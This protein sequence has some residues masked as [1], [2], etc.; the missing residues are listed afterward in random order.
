LAGT[1][2]QAI[3]VLRH[4][5][6]SRIHDRSSKRKEQSEKASHVLPELTGTAPRGGQSVWPRKLSGLD[7]QYEV[8]E[9]CPA[10]RGVRNREAVPASNFYWQHACY[11]WRVRFNYRNRDP[12]RFSRMPL[13][14]DTKDQ[15]PDTDLDH[16]VPEQGCSAIPLVVR[17]RGLCWFCTGPLETKT[18]GQDRRSCNWLEA[19]ERQAS[20]SSDIPPAA[21]ATSIPMS[22]CRSGCSIISKS[23]GRQPER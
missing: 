3:Q 18:L 7:V 8:D 1:L 16:L 13:L 9:L 23:S 22:W 11:G 15:T 6:D 4:N 2:S 14:Q 17:L 21:E 12:D 20:A 19:I 5:W 10:P